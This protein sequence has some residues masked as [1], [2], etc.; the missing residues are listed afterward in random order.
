MKLNNACLWLVCLGFVT[1]SVTVLPSVEALAAESGA[2]LLVTSDSH[3][4]AFE[5]EDRNQ[6]DRVTVHQM[7]Q[8]VLREPDRTER[9]EWDGSWGWRFL[10]NREL[11]NQASGIGDILSPLRTISDTSFLVDAQAPT[12]RGIG[13]E[14]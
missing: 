7:N 14:P 1:T 13:T 12:P 5:N 10:R 2:T 4:D 3:Y 8:P 9:R 6:R 11:E